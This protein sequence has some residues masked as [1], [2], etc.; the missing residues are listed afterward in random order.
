[1]KMMMMMIMMILSLPKVFLGCIGYYHYNTRKLGGGGINWAKIL[2]G[3][4]LPE[5]FAFSPVLL[6]P[7]SMSRRWHRHLTSSCEPQDNTLLCAWWG[8]PLTP[9]KHFHTGSAHPG[10]IEI[11]D[12]LSSTRQ[13][14]QAATHPSTNRGQCCLTCRIWLPPYVPCHHLPCNTSWEHFVSHNIYYMSH[15]IDKWIYIA[16]TSL[17]AYL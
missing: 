8:N 4:S 5:C 9:Y 17:N 10:R 12:L 6:H 11:I 7:P 3:W 15:T 2:W 14:A 13:P 16:H 1:M